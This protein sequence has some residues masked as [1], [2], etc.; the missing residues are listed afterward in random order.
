MYAA[1]QIDEPILQSRLIIAPCYAIHPRSRIL[2]Q[3]FKTLP[4]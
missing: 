2:L 1:V 3:C 4:Q